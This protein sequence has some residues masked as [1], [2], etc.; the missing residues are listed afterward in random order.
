MV[1]PR[2]DSKGNYVVRKRLPDDVREEYG[3][4]YGTRSE[5]KRKIPAG[6]KPRIVKQQ[7]SELIAEVEGRIAHIRAVRKGESLSL[8]QRQAR[9]LAGEW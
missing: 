2:Q 4:L 1:T 6:T 7:T 8:S 5:V 9:A 3:R